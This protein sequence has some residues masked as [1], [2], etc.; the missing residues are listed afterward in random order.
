[1]SHSPNEIAA[2]LTLEMW[3]KHRTD[4]QRSSVWKAVSKN[5][6]LSPT[7]AH[8]S[9]CILLQGMGATWGQIKHLRQWY[10]LHGASYLDPEFCVGVPM[11]LDTFRTQ[12]EIEVQGWFVNGQIVEAA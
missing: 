2:R 3:A 11:D 7:E 8:L 10:R 5:L 1:M 12:V 6:P 9:V 4:A